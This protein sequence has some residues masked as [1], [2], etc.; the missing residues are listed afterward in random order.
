MRSNFGVLIL[1]LAACGGS[2]STGPAS[3]PFDL[4]AASGTYTIALA[5]TGTFGPS[6][7]SITVNMSAPRSWTTSCY[8]GVVT[9]GAVT[10]SNDTLRLAVV[11]V[12]PGNVLDFRLT[13]FGGTEA[14]PTSKWIG[15]YCWTVPAGCMPEY[16][17][18]N[19]RR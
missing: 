16:G 4:A 8:A 6:C 13:G 18:A 10:I 5:I 7:T 14:K 19:W 17:N 3:P 11:P 1:L 12:G 9:P 2:D 15:G